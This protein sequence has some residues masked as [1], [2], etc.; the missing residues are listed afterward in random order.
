MEDYLYQKDLWQP[1]GGKTKKLTTM[2]AKDWDFLDRKA[3]RSI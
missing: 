3:L 1:L 2:L